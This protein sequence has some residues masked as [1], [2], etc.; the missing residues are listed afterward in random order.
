M[1][2][3]CTEIHTNINTFI[4]TIKQICLL[5]PMQFTQIGAAFQTNVTTWKIPIIPTEM[6]KIMDI[7][8]VITKWNITSPTNN[9]GIVLI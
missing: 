8:I 5:K 6:A 2:S 9:S 3:E 1:I 4:R 7:T